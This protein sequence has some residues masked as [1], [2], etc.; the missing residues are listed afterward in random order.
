[1]VAKQQ[2]ASG[3]QQKRL[4]RRLLLCLGLSVTFFYAASFRFL[5]DA[6]IRVRK[7]FFGAPSRVCFVAFFLAVGEVDAASSPVC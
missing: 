4:R 2:K 5:A 1:M 6:L 3:P 7:W